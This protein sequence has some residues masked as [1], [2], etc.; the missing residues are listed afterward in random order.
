MENKL[1]DDEIE[2]KLIDN[3]KALLYKINDSK[4]KV[5]NDPIIKKWL[6]SQKKER[7]ENGI[8]AYCIE[9]NLF[10]YFISK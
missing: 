9:C 2:L 10:F 1:I 8:A 5:N 4:K 3:I 6:E 7:G